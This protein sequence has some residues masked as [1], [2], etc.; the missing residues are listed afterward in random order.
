MELRPPPATRP[1]RD[2]LDATAG[3]RR[4]DPEPV[5]H[6]G[7]LVEVVVPHARPLADVAEEAVALDDL[8]LEL[9]DLGLGG[10][11]DVP[12]GEA[13]EQ[14]HA[15][16]NPEDRPP[17][18]GDDVAESSRAAGSCA[19]QGAVEPE[20]TTAWAPLRSRASR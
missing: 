18:R 16:A 2:R 5:G 4:E 20:S 7:Q 1:A 3:G 8:D 15:R 11:V 13:P 14:L 19:A 12:A 10:V 9:A 6:V 17:A